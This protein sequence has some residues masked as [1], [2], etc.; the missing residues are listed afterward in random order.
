MPTRNSADSA[1]TLHDISNQPQRQEGQD[2]VANEISENE[3]K[4]TGL[5]QQNNNVAELPESNHSEST[6]GGQPTTTGDHAEQKEL[7]KE[8]ADKDW[9]VKFDGDDDPDNPRSMSK[10]RKWLI[11]MVVAFSSLCV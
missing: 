7:E 1:S 5:E 3:P 9:I 11:T 4:A 2:I 10:G 6:I 8:E